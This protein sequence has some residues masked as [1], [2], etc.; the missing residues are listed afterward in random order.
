MPQP[1]APD[2]ARRNEHPL[3]AQLIGGPGLTI[4]RVLV[5]HLE[6]GRLDLRHNPVLQA[7]LPAGLLPQ[8][9]DALLLISS[10]DVV[11]VLAGHAVDF[12]GLRDVL[13]VLSQ[14]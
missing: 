11:K 4:G 12:A 13:K 8:P 2:A 14:L 10:F 7:G 6:H 3:L 5:G 1:D 9:L